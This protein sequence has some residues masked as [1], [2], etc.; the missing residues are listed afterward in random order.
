[1]ARNAL[2]IFVFISLCTLLIFVALCFPFSPSIHTGAPYDRIGS[3][4]PMYIIRRTSCLSPQ[5]ILAD[6]ESAWMIFMHYPVMLFICW[7]KLNLLSMV[8]PRYFIV[9]SCW[10]FMLLRKILKSRLF[11][12]FFL[13]IIATFDFRSSKL[14]L[15]FLANFAIFCVSVSIGFHFY[16]SFS[17][18]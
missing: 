11:L 9:S 1:V 2:A 7:L 6:F 5:L 4:A 17:F 3:I 13:V 12:G 15:L 10:S 8:M 14:I 16:L 18:N